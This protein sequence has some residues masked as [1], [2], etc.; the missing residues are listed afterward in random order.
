MFDYIDHIC[1]RLEALLSAGTIV[2]FDSSTDAFVVDAHQLWPRGV[3]AAF[4]AHR[5]PEEVALMLWAS[6]QEIDPVH[7]SEPR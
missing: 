4:E 7:Y 6:L 2:E 3:L 1:D 5:D